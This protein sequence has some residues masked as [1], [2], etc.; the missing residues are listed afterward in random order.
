MPRS[1]YG[2]ILLAGLFIIP[3]IGFG[4]QPS[5]DV[6][7]IRSSAAY[8]EIL[9]RKT[10]ILADIEAFSADYT[11]ANPRLLDL[12]FELSALDRSLEKVFG[13]KSA[14]TGKL[15]LALGKLIVRKAALE[16]ELARLT[17]SYKADHPEVKRAKR[18][19][20]IF[21]SAIKEVLR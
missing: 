1:L 6:G 3:A 12:R 10:E 13:V 4:Q 8:S 18:R 9:L 14:E 11:E 19:V 16:T 5:S 2:I 21:D 20:E 7:S 17:R 15:T